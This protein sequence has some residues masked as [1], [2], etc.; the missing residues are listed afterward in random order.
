[1]LRMTAAPFIPADLEAQL[2]AAGL[3]WELSWHPSTR[4]TQQV[5][6]QLV[7]AHGPRHWLI[8]AG[9]Q[10]AGRGRMD[11]M[12]LS[13]PGDLA[14]TWVWP[15]ELPP[16]RWGKLSLLGGLVMAQAVREVTGQ[17][18]VVKWPNDLFIAGRKIGGCLGEILRPGTRFAALLGIGLNLMP[19]DAG[20]LPDLPLYP[21]GHLETLDPNVTRMD[22]LLAISRL[23]SER[24]DWARPSHDVPFTAWWQELAMP[25][26]AP[27]QATLQG[28][29]EP[30]SGTI[31]GLAP[32]GA[33]LIRTGTGEVQ[34]VIAGD[35]KLRVP[36]GE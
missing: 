23:L 5:A 17:T 30:V 19:K 29:A 21:I 35:V 33:L 22:L 15:L 8:A 24:R 27:V 4:S 16:E 6:R 7:Q 20:R 1:M 11:R 3:P 12:W 2:L 36:L 25:L 13:D 32:T 10:E 28:Q 9:Q 26:D 14:A 18:A 31:A 34:E